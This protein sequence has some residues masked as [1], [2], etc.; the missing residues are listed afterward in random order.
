M[1]VVGFISHNLQYPRSTSPYNKISTSAKNASP[2]LHRLE[3]EVVVVDDD[4]GDEVNWS[5]EHESRPI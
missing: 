5:V 4:D 2:S 1:V 3:E